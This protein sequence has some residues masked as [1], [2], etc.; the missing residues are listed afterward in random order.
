ML[1]LNPRRCEP[2]FRELLTTA[3]RIV[4][5]IRDDGCERS[6][7]GA[8]VCRLHGREDSDTFSEAESSKALQELGGCLDGQSLEAKAV[9]RDHR[10]AA[11]GQLAINDGHGLERSLRE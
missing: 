11:S 3:E 7:A 5:K 8:Y 6:Q 2:R 10:D 4:L 1:C 9:G